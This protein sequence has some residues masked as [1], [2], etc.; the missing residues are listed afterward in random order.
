M[1]YPTK[2]GNPMSK[3]AGFTSRPRQLTAIFLILTLSALAFGQEQKPRSFE[4]ASIK[5]A[6]TLTP[7]LIA[8]GKLHIGMKVDQARVDIGYVSLAD[9]IPI[10]F[11]LKPYQVSGPDWLKGSQRFDILATLP[12]GSNKD[13]VPEMLQSLLAERFQLKYHRETRELPIY[14]L[15]VSKSGHKLKGSVPEAEA[16]AEPPKEGAKDNALTLNAGDSKIQIRPDPDGATITSPEVGKMK[17]S[18]DRESGQMH[19][20]IEKV[21][22]EQFAALLSQLVDRPVFDKTELKGNFQVSLTLSI[23]NLLLIARSSGLNLPLPAAGTPGVASDPSGGSSVFASVKQLGLNLEPQK[24]PAEF[25]VVDQLE[26]MPT[27]N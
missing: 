17:M 25:L 15:V 7:A 11:K 24:A 10:A 18:L 14:A 3:L 16:P 20:E 6:E 12:E 21:S 13:Q 5:P 19:M 23:E 26:K 27:E 8:S 4:V 9:L 22:M 2:G 1:F